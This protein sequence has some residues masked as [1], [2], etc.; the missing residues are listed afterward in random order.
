M[1]GGKQGGPQQSRHGVNI[2]RTLEASGWTD[3]GRLERCKQK[4]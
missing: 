4:E 3:V 2:A 1:I